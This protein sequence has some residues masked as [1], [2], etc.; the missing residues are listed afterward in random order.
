M[1]NM[2]P[3][4]PQIDLSDAPNLECSACGD[5]RFRTDIVIF[6]KISAILSPTGQAGVVPTGPYPSCAS[7]GNINDEFL[8]PD[9]RKAPPVPEPPKPTSGKP[10][11][12]VLK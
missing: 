5:V 3:Q 12:T 7:C 4:G 9:M 11:F 6:K 1:N 8:P 2:P 10:I